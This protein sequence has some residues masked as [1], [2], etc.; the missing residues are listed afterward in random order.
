M[1]SSCCNECVHLIRYPEG[2][3][4]CLMK[5]EFCMV[6]GKNSY[7]KYCEYFEGEM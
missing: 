3:L 4:T 7:P 6:H 1:E 2:G 5:Q